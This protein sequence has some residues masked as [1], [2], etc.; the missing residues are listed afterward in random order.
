M[1]A[2][3]NVAVDPEF[4]VKNLYSPEVIANP[5][6]YYAALRD[7][8]IQFGLED[9][10][11]GTIPGVDT[12]RPA[13]VILKH[14]HVFE[15][16][17]RADVFSSRDIMQEESE[18]PTLMLVNHD[19][20][21]HRPL[22]RIAQI[23][24]TPK[25][26]VRDVAPWLNA[27]VSRLLD[28][29]GP[30]EL[31]LM[32]NLAPD[33]PALVM[34]KLIGLP[35]EDA[36]LLR[37]WAN[38]FMVTSDFTI[39]ERMQCNVELFGYFTEAVK[40][41]YAAIER[42]EDTPDDLMSAFIRAEAEGASLT[43]EEVVRFCLT[44]VVAGAETTVYLLGNL[45]DVLV[46]EPG[47]FPLLQ[48]DRS[49]IRP[50]IE[51]SLR[52]DGPVQRLHRVC[53]EDTRI[54]DA[55]I[56]AGDWVAIFHASANRDPDVFER[57]DEFILNRPNVSKHATFG[58]GIHHCMGAGIARNEAAELING[59]L[60]RFKAIEPAGPRVR[61]RGGLLNYGLETCPVRLIA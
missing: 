37:R 14:E 60:D 30:G 51:E 52:R 18:A 27:T 50:F 22:R 40:N 8:P 13:W 1:G 34:T 7:R 20:P 2:A 54:G 39:E 43:K 24:F 57:P 47:H 29:I 9:Y 17:K 16:C 56:A 21:E 42:G 53:V 31:D 58:H 4:H 45:I 49:L 12:P 48:E 46:S 15:V 5:Y 28:E 36:H 6:P 59:L 26:V 23:A 61:Q 38:A 35:E 10:P 3:Q 33:L 55:E 25:R 44:L 19:E 32:E 41:R 11:P